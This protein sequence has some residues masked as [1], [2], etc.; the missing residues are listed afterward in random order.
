MNFRELARG[1][2]VFDK[3]TEADENVH[4]RHAELFACETPPDAMASGEVE[5][6]LALGWRWDG[7]EECWRHFT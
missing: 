5:E 4:A 6:L 2:A 3:Y 7:F 1:V